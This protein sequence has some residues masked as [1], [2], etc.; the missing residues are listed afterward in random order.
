LLAGLLLAK[1]AGAGLDV[2]MSAHAVLKHGEEAK[3]IRKCIDNNGPDSTW[4]FTS[5]RRK[6]HFIRTC[7][8]PDGRWGIQIIQA[9]A[10]GLIER[11]AFVIKDGTFFQLKEYVTARAVEYTGNLMTLVP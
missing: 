4:T 7:Q 5:H 2:R 3:A 1:Q 11:T 6:D 9:T 8:L 10:R